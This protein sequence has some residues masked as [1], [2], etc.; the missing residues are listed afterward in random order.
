[1]RSFRGR[2]MSGRSRTVFSDPVAASSVD[3][4]IPKLENDVKD[5]TYFFYMHVDVPAYT[6]SYF[7][8]AM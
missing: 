8:A 6:S 7:G 1:M 5:V 2:L 4:L 3:V